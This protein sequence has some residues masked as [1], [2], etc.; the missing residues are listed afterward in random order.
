MLQVLGWNLGLKS[1]VIGR[2]AASV[3]VP[4]WDDLCRRSIED[5][6]YYSPKYAW[7]L[8]DS[9]E[10]DERVRFATVWSHDTLV[11]LLPF[12]TPRFPVPMLG[13]AGRGWQSKYTFSC[14]PLLDEAHASEAA[15][16]LVALLTSVAPGEW[17][18]PSLN[19]EGEV[20][21]ALIDA[22][23]RQD[24]PWTF[25]NRFQRAML[26]LGLG[27]DEH[28]KQHIC[29]KRRREL[30]RNRRRLEQLGKLEYHAYCSGDELTRAINLFLEIEKSGWK[31]KKGTALACSEQGRNFALAAFTGE[32]RN[33]ICRADLLTLNGGPIAVNLTAM[34]GA[35]GFTVK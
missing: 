34:A 30:A 25:V 19:T 3:L 7:A 22:L 18:L 17:I 4:A 26:E 28:M 31:G 9:V 8:L 20:C 11:A 15:N 29:A 5:N 2:D 23:D 14:M 12:T 35:T 32:E 21:H 27:F 6:V 13:P 16:A 10:R 24:R 33:S 1:E